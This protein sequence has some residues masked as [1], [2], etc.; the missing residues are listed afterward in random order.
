VL[1]PAIVLIALTFPYVA[2][3]PN[4]VLFVGEQ[5]YAP[6]PISPFE[7]VP[8]AVTAALALGLAPRLPQWDRY[9]T[10]HT[11]W[12]A[13]LCALAV[14]VVPIGVFFA[15][16]QLYPADG[17][18]PAHALIPI[19]SDI[20][21]AGL[22][23][24]ILLGTLGRLV[25]IMA[26]IAALYATMFAQSFAPA[27]GSYLPLSIAYRPDLSI[28]NS[29]RWWWILALTIGAGAVVWIRRSVPIRISLRPP[30]ET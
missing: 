4:A 28:D 10:N 9:G 8:L 12:S 1:T 24:V 7:Y 27:W 17:R 19:A 18:P 14:V 26:W 30:E 2:L 21:V 6:R 23:L 25:G 20:A 16:L 29:I 3:W 11:R 13:A 5:N 22:G 15:A